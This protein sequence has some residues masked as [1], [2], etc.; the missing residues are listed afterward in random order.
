MMQLPWALL[1]AATSEG[2][3]GA[4]V[5]DAPV[6]AVDAGNYSRPLI[7]LIV[8]DAKC[9]DGT[10]GGYY[11]HPSA[12]GSSK[13][14][15]TLQGGG[16]CVT[17]E[18]CPGK[19][20]SHLGS[21]KHFDSSFS[22][23]RDSATHF[24]D[25]DCKGNPTLC[26]YNLVYLPYCSQDLWSGRRTSA[27]PETY[28]YY[29]S[30]HLIF[31]AVLESLEAT[32]DL[33]GASEIIL[34]GTSAGGFGVYTNLDYVAQR[35]PSAKVVGA[36]IA[37]FEFYAWPYHGPGHTSST[38]ADFREVAMASGKYNQL[39]CVGCVL[40]RQ[41]VA[42]RFDTFCSYIGNLQSLDLVHV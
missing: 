37:G 40:V 39:W 32:H 9:M 42:E 20:A 31:Q 26:E 19:A 21:S 11:V 22:F 34:T 17:K 4:P 12:T 14:V 6:P 41:H 24:I 36:P 3:S 25:A 7:M 13:W 15:L 8:D 2:V 28:G 29:F 5:V 38:L 33:R 16:E 10:Q 1:L 18:K 27:S 35:Y 23:F 30:G